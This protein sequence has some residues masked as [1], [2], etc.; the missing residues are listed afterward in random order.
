MPSIEDNMSEAEWG[1]DYLGRQMESIADIS[2]ARKFIR[3]LMVDNSSNSVAV[4]A[5]GLY[6]GREKNVFS[7]SVAYLY[8]NNKDFQRKQ[9]IEKLLNEFS[10]FLDFNRKV[11][12][13]AETK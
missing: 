6:L 11:I 5:M 2:E 12:N 10:F 13:W 1:R 4:E 8:W 3:R 9:F 7:N